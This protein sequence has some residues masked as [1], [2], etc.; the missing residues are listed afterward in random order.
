MSNRKFCWVLF[1][2]MALGLLLPQM[3]FSADK[4]LVVAFRG[5]AARLDPHSRNETTTVTIQRHFYEPLVVLDMDLKPT[6]GLAE[7]WKNID[8]LT[9]EFKLRKGVTFTN[10]HNHCHCRM[11]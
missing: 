7:S 4:P 1:T 9:W 11:G 6:P 2:V 10:G 3:G 5:D 8:T